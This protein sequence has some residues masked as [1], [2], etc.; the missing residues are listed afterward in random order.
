VEPDTILS[1]H[2]LARVAEVDP[3]DVEELGT[4]DGVGPILAG[5]F[6]ADILHALRGSHQRSE[7]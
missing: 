7:M 5:R 3:D 4:I 6:G 2:V 1:D